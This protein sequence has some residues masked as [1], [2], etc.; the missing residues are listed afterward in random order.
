MTLHAPRR[1]AA[2]APVP[3][4]LNCPVSVPTRPATVVYTSRRVA[5]VPVVVRHFVEVPVIHIAV[6]H[7]L[8]PSCIVIERS[9]SPKFTPLS[10]RD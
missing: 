10:V 1:A 8:A 3:S 9:D 6:L 4:K 5:P 7:R 2:Q